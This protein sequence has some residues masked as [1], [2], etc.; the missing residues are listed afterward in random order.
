MK[1]PD[2]LLQAVYLA[3][4]MC[5]GQMTP[6]SAARSIRFLTAAELQSTLLSPDENIRFNGRNYIM[7]V[8]D[9]LMLTKSS[10]IC[11]H[12]QTEINQITELVRLQLQ[13]RPELLRFNAASV[14]REVMVANYP[15][16]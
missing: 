15:C 14:V 3:G 4:L 9:S 16:I 1:R 11:M 13:Q 10:P 6:V 7:G 2:K 5:F 8:V 12:E